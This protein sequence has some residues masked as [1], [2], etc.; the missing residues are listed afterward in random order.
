MPADGRYTFF[1]NVDE[2]SSFW[3]KGSKWDLKRLLGSQELAERFSGGSAV[4]ARLAPPD[5]HRFHFPVSGTANAPARVG[6]A[7]YSVNPISLRR[8]PEVFLEN[9]RFITEIISPEFGNVLMIE[10]GA[11][12]VG[13]VKQTA[14]L[15]GTVEKGAEKGYFSFG[16]SAIVLLF[17]K[18]KC[19]FEPD[20]LE[21]TRRGFELF[22][23]MGES[24]AA[25]RFG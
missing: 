15:P 25:P 21:A 12:N 13:S 24:L 17:E 2:A 3:I 9:K 19:T 20:L 22:C 7:L 6:K 11:T 4:L 1:E 16:A 8:N 10:V 14:E 23:R 18:G 5:Y